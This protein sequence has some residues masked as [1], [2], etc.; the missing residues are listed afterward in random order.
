MSEGYDAHPS[1]P[2]FSESFILCAFAFRRGSEVYRIKA[3]S[4][5]YRPELAWKSDKVS[6]DVFSGVIVDGLVY[7]FDIQDAQSNENGGTGGELVCIELATGKEQWRTNAVGHTSVLTDGKL[8]YLFTEGCELVVAAAAGDA[9]KEIARSEILPGELSWTEPAFYGDYMVVRSQTQLACVYLGDSETITSTEEPQRL[10][11][12]PV[13]RWLER[14][15]TASFLNPTN[16][17][18]FLWSMASLICGTAL[19]V[20]IGIFTHKRAHLFWPISLVSS[21]V[22]GFLGLFGFTT[23]RYSGD[24]PPDECVHCSGLSLHPHCYFAF[25][26]FSPIDL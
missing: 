14:Y 22:L 7:A 17:D 21:L 2:L 3:A 23:L 9:Y 11:G 20:L 12:G 15:R 13:T 5:T 26:G 6:M 24:L 8:L 18:W 4:G 16:R 1:W 25:G 10:V 19:P